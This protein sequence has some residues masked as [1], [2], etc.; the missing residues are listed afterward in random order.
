MAHQGLRSGDR[1]ER[2]AARE[3]VGVDAARH[4]CIA[5]VKLRHFLDARETRRLR[6]AQAARAEGALESLY[7]YHPPLCIEAQLPDQ[8]D[9]LRRAGRRCGRCAAQR[10]DRRQRITPALALSA[11][12]GGRFGEGR[13]QTGCQCGGRCQLEALTSLL[14]QE[15]QPVVAARSERCHHL[16]H[17]F[18]VP[19]R[20]LDIEPGGEQQA[21]REKNAVGRVQMVLLGLLQRECVC[22]ESFVTEAHRH[23]MGPAAPR[24]MRRGLARTR[25]GHAKFVRCAPRRR[26]GLGH[27]SQWI[28]P[29][30]PHRHRAA[31][32]AGCRQIGFVGRGEGLASGHPFAAQRGF[33]SRKKSC[34]S[35]AG[36]RGQ[37]RVQSR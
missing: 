9:R 27:Q 36:E 17:A 18:S 8:C 15:R 26:R 24:V 2:Q 34:Q 30:Q 5:R 1:I 14:Q 35:G 23:R 31:F 12:K 21:V 11:K 28:K 22:I 33:S 19:A 13:A 32:Q 16:C 4:R 20:R 37:R 3:T 10:G 6:F 7:V 25:L 29:H